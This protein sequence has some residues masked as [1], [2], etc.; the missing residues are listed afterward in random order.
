[1]MHDLLVAT[2]N[3]A[4]L[5][6]LR[7]GLASLEAQH[8]RLLTLDDFRITAEPE[9]TGTTF[10]E[11]ARLKAMYYGDK[12]GKPALADDGG[13]LIDILHGEPGVKS[14]RWLG[15]DASDE[16]LIAYTLKRLEGVAAKDRGARL[17]TNVC[18][19]NPS[20]KLL[21]QEEEHVAGTIA[22]VPSGRATNGYPFRALFIITQFN[23]YYDELTDADHLAINHRLKALRRMIP[24]IGRDLLQ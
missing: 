24:S 23:K 20:T 9:E 19:Y 1:M 16:E 22:V 10:S 5:A 14:R 11:N 13:V 4:K 17:Q 7:L 2:H 18:Y 6:E 15:Y 3:K 21:V 8:V 12:T